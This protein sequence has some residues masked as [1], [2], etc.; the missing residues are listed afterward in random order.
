MSSQAKKKKKKKK[1]KIAEQEQILHEIETIKETQ[2]EEY[3]FY[4]NEDDKSVME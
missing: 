1:K 3:N 2:N 4:K